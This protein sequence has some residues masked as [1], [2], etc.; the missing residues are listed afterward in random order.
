MQIGSTTKVLTHITQ[1]QSGVSWLPLALLMTFT[2]GDVTRS[3]KPIT[4]AN[5]SQP[6]EFLDATWNLF[7]ALRQS[8]RAAVFAVSR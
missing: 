5:S 4:M 7:V 6:I 1:L 2:L 3:V 8:V